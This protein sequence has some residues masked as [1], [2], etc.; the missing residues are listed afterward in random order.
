MKIQTSTIIRT[1]VL[2]ITLVNTFLTM[3][4]CNPLPF[5][6]EELYEII[7]RMEEDG[8]FFES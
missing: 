1:I 2:A 4:G 7:R 6:E 3:A 5:S 8:F